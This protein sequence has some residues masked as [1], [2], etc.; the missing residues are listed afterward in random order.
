MNLKIKKLVENLSEG[1][2]IIRD[3]SEGGKYGYSTADAPNIMTVGFKTQEQ[4]YQHWLKSRLG[5]KIANA[6]IELISES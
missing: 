5:E 1:I 6:I 3:N 2:T 4:A